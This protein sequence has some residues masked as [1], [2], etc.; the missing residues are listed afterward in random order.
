MEE[1]NSQKL[2][3]HMLVPSFQGKPGYLVGGRGCQVSLKAHWV[4]G[5]AFVLFLTQKGAS[6]VAQW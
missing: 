2:A 1:R 6:Q 4:G 5:G 3:L